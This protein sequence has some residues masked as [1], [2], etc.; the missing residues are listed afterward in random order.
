M[1]WSIAKPIT[2]KRSLIYLCAVDFVGTNGI[3]KM[4]YMPINDFYTD[5][6]FMFCFVIRNVNICNQFEDF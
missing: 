1:E 5:F 2:L 3:I 4:D 6:A